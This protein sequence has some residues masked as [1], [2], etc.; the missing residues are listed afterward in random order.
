MQSI[1]HLLLAVSSIAII[2]SNS[3][4][5]KRIIMVLFPG[6]NRQHKSIKELFDHSI[7]NPSQDHEFEYH[8]IIYKTDLPFWKI[9]SSNNYLFYSYGNGNEGLNDFDGLTGVSFI[10]NY[11]KWLMDFSKLF[12]QTNIMTQLTAQQSPPRFD[13]IITDIPNYVSVLIQQE[14]NIPLQMYLSPRPFPQLLFNLFELNTN[15]VPGIGSESSD[16]MNFGERF[17]NFFSL[18]RDKY[19]HWRLQKKQID[20]YAKYHYS[21]KSDM[22]MRDSF[23][24]IQYP[25][26]LVF[27]MSVP[28]N[29]IF[30]NAIG[31][32]QG[33]AIS[34]I[35]VNDFISGH[36]STIYITEK[37]SE[38]LKESDL[39]DIS[40]KFNIGFVI[41][42]NSTVKES[43]SPNIITT[44]IDAMDLIAHHDTKCIISLGDI[45]IISQS[46][47]NYKPMIL[48]NKGLM[49]NN[50]ISFAI[51]KQIG[52]N[53]E[54]GKV[55]KERL[56]EYLNS[57]CLNDADNYYKLNA[58]AIGHILKGNKDAK[59]EYVHWLDY[60]FKHSYNTLI[61]PLYLK[62]SWLNIN[63]LDVFVFVLLI[64][65]GLILFIR[66]IL[67]SML[68]TCKKDKQRPKVKRD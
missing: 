10:T 20:L 23:N 60:G 41:Q 43:N 1:Y 36:K 34:S 24:M 5:T 26:G 8:I 48:L 47:Y 27:P 4:Q 11:T 46:L 56:A 57:V 52:I 25:K 12:L 21:L 3:L 15:Y 51:H 37:A 9:N 61:V 22:F 42:G 35:G 55:T 64:A 32:R 14:L 67:N 45:D 40:I 29:F 6:G 31:I 39:I 2:N 63:C 7:H 53:V 58:K 18:M 54:E 65:I 16:R 30:L 28:P 59:K 49:Q 19:I 38:L 44:N 50:I 13:L 33:K 17:N 62:G 68:G 66:F